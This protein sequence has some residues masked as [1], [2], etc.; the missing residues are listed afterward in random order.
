MS[1]SSLVG[2][3][4]DW[5]SLSGC[6]FGAP[7]NNILRS[8]N[9]LLKTHW[10]AFCDIFF[11]LNSRCIYDVHTYIFPH[12]HICKHR[13]V[14]I[15]PL[16]LQ[17]LDLFLALSCLDY[18]DSKIDHGTPE[19]RICCNLCGH[20]KP[21]ID[22]HKTVRDSI[23]TLILCSK[24]YLHNNSITIQKA[25]FRSNLG[26]TVLMLSPR[27]GEQFSYAIQFQCPDV[28]CKWF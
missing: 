5:T 28:F 26:T 19:G 1:F 27:K 21:L 14:D 23:T 20:N 24:P 11:L 15:F 22:Y 2:V 18:H 9:L 6:P 12:T 3:S 8:K 10:P 4:T 7:S 25:I 17:K 16:Q 13:Y